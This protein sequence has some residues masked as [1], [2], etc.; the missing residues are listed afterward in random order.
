M[1]KLAILVVAV[2]GCGGSVPTPAGGKPVRAWI[3][4]LQ[5]P[6]AHV[7]KKA[8][9]KL[10]NVGAADPEALPAL[11]GAL[12]DKESDV[13]CEAIKALVKFGPA[14]NEVMVALTPLRQKD[15]D[16]KVRICAAKAL[17]ALRQAG[18]K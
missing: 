13:R 18:T 8:V 2:G 1:G 7:R 11:I 15:R 9:L 6:A 5:D 12:K 3:E 17:E 14:A 4:A 10:G 16:P